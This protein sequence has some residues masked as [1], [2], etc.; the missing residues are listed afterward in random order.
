MTES[1]KTFAGYC[2]MC[3]KSLYAEGDKKIW[4]H[5]CGYRRAEY[6]PYDL[7]DPL[8]PANRTRHHD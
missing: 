8:H 2:G 7:S 5:S 1:S 3:G 6:N 4:P